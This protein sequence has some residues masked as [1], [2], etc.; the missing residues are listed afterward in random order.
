MENQLKKWIY[1]NNA[2]KKRS[3]VLKIN[4]FEGYRPSLE[5]QQKSIKIWIFRVK[6]TNV[7]NL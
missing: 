3:H 2:I 5:S 4:G 6:D 7:Y 1:Y